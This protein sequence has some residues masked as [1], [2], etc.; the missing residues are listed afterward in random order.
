MIAN[1]KENIKAQLIKEFGLDQ[2]SVEVPKR[3]DAD[4]AIPLFGYVKTLGLPVTE[5]FEKFKGVLQTLPEI[6]KT[7]FIAGFLNI[8]LKRTDLAL[9]IL[10]KIYNEKSNYGTKP[11]NGK[12]VVMDY[13]SP[14]IAKSFSVGHLRSTVIGNSLKQIYVKNGWNAVGIN[15]LGDW[16]TQFGRMIVAYKKWGN[17]ELIEKN[18]I[19]ELQKLYVKFHEEEVNDPSLDQLG[20]DVFLKLEQGDPEYTALWQY[21]RDE[22]LKEFTEMYKLLDVSFD[23]YNGE[24]F[25]N[26]KMDSVVEELEAK[27]LLVED[28]GAKVVQLGEGIPPVLIKRSDGGTLYATRDLAAIFWRKKEYNFDKALYIV[29]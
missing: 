13:S 6:E 4:L 8:Y 28:Q 3:G 12:T 14:N 27:G 16:G 11:S 20:R 25:Y 26:D 29:G 19:A 10:N 21:F 7:V 5:V 1:I 2:V 24:A 9:A 17:K 18:P 23:S 22:S 15:Y